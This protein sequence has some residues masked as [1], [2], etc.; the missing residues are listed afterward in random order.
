[1]HVPK[2]NPKAKDNAT[3]QPGCIYIHNLAKFN[4]DLK[5]ML[6]PF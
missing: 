2:A 4:L 1:M 6:F 3:A 5:K